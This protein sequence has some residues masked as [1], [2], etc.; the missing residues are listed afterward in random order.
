MYGEKFIDM[1]EVNQPA[2]GQRDLLGP[3]HL[4]IELDDDNEGICSSRS[5][6]YH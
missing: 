6:L 1:C 2:L 3:N 4:N 5:S